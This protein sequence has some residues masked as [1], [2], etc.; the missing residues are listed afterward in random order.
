MPHELKYNLNVAFNEFLGFLPQKLHIL[1][2]FIPTLDHPRLHARPDLIS[3][4][5]GVQLIAEI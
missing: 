4:S 2:G 1:V 3:G 5:S